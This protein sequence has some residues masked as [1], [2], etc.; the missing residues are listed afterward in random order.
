M[1]PTDTK[2][3]SILLGLVGYLLWHFYGLLIFVLPMRIDHVH[4]IS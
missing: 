4:D 1:K 3:M 2:K